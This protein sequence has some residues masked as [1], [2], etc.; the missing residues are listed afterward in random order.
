M[1]TNELL[2]RYDKITYQY[3]EINPYK[4]GV[5]RALF[6]LLKANESK[7]QG[8]IEDDETGYW[9]HKAFRQIDVCGST[10][11]DM[12]IWLLLQKAELFWKMINKEE[13]WE[14]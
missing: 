2:E 14:V 10:Y 3:L 13:L 11:I 8:L 12:S 5:E 6:N 4:W 7:I 9:F 1:T